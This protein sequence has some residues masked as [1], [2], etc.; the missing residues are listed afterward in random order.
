MLYDI[1]IHI[2]MKKGKEFLIK[3]SRKFSV[4]VLL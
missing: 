1:F 2:V 4:S 3:D